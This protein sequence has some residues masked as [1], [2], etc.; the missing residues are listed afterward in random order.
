MSPPNE[1]AWMKGVRVDSVRMLR[2]VLKEAT[3]RV[4]EEGKGMLVEALMEQRA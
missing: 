1:G 3:T 4:Q 2:E